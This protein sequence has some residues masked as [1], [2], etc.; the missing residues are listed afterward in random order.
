MNLPSLFLIYFINEKDVVC[1]ENLLR[2]FSSG[3][4][5]YDCRFS[6]LGFTIVVVIFFPVTRLT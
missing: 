4:L 5:N 1:A 2:S 6:F 3:G